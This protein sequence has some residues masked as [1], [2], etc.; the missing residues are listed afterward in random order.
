[1]TFDINN[2]KGKTA[3]ELKAAGIN[4]EDLVKSYTLKEPEIIDNQMD[5]HIRILLEAGYAIGE[6]ISAGYPVK[7]LRAAGVTDEQLKDACSSAGLEQYDYKK[8]QNVSDAAKS[9]NR[10]VLMDEYGCIYEG[11][12]CNGKPNGHGVQTWFFGKGCYEGGF[13]NGDFEGQGVLDKPDG[14]H[15]EGSF[16]DSL[17]HGR[18]VC[19]YPSGTRYDGE[20]VNGLPQGSG[21]VYFTDGTRFEGVFSRYQ[22]FEHG[23]DCDE[24]SGEGFHID[25]EGN[26]EAKVWVLY[27]R[28]GDCTGCCIE[29]K[30][31]YFCKRREYLL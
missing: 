20:F 12:W 2:I 11:D 16:H 5:E 4:V 22:A 15:Y 17:F 29:D 28:E 30:R 18:G 7:Q 31:E 23:G 13:I 1:M 21:T 3:E 19:T 27:R 25:T 9:E 10:R 26:K 14:T 6:L 8:P 24:V